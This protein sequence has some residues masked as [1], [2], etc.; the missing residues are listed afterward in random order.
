MALNT[1]DYSAGETKYIVLSE[2]SHFE[3]TLSTTGSGEYGNSVDI[4]FTLKNGE[5]SNRWWGGL[6][7]SNS[8]VSNR[9]IDLQKF[10]ANSKTDPDSAVSSISFSLNNY[11]GE[12]A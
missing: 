11:G 1:W 4:F 10:A 3:L 9:T 2:Y 7:G 12:T 8:S 6:W 5:T